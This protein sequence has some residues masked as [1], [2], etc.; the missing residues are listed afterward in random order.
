MEPKMRVKI[1]EILQP[2]EFYAIRD[3]KTDPNRVKIDKWQEFVGQNWRL[4]QIEEP[5]L[6]LIPNEII[7]V[8]HDKNV[9][10]RGRILEIIPFSFNKIHLKMFLIDDGKYHRVTNVT[11][12]ACLVPE[13]DCLDIDDLAFKFCLFG[14]SRKIY[15]CFHF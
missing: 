6:S 2:N 7:F 14:N 13:R 9:W 11:Q 15:I 4:L 5:E 10:K 1:G 12:D 8:R 3:P